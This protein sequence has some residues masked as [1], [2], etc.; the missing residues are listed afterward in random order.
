MGKK[1][2]VLSAIACNADPDVLSAAFPLLEAGEVEALEWS[3][4]ALLG[5]MP[6]WFATLLGAYGE[7]GRLVGHGV[8]F[9]L[10]SGQWT[11]EQQQ[12]LRDLSQLA[13]RFSFDHVT[14]H[15]GFFTGENFHAGAPLPVPCSA[16]TLRLGRDRLRRIQEAGQCPV[17]LENLALA[18]SLDDVQQQGTFLDQLLE[19]VNGFLILDLHNLYCQLHNFAVAPEALLD[20]YPLDRV[21]EIHI[22][23]GSWEDSAQ[24]PR[25]QVRRDTHDGAVPE[26][27]F[28]LLERTMP[29]CPHLK[30]VVLEQLGTA[31][32]TERRRARF[33]QDFR[34]MA[35]LGQQHNLATPSGSD[36]LFMPRHPSPTGPVVVDE[37]LH[38]QQRQLS[39]ILEAA[40]TLDEA[41]RLLHA[42]SLAHTEWQLENWA[43]YM[44]DT[45]RRIAQKW[46]R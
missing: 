5:E 1:P 13:A 42:S 38:G 4:D 32:K 21:R 19:P 18:Y 2:R 16:A 12:W 23:G 14:E 6:D 41:Q 8:Y 28:Q 39:R 11:P 31:L 17:G 22:S 20:L 25:G 46:K 27:V 37:K 44:L 33:R 29:R 34:R 7:Q 43:P 24:A 35:R 10:L 26:E 3:F 9:S 40:P 30:Y 45:A 15:F 36:R